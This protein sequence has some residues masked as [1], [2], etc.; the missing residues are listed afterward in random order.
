MTSKLDRWQL[1]RLNVHENDMLGI[2]INKT[3]LKDPFPFQFV[4]S[5]NDW[6]GLGDDTPNAQT[7]EIG[8]ANFLFDPGRTG[9]NILQCHLFDNISFNG[10]LSCPIFR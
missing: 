6:Y 3:L 8:T 10:Q 9:N 7:S 5:T 4:S 2:K 1:K